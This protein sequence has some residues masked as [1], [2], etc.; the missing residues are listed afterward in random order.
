MEDGDDDEVLLS[1]LE[2]E[3]CL[4]LSR[5]ESL[6]RSSLGESGG[7]RLRPFP[8][9]ELRRQSPLGEREGAC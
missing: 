2:V 1:S 5:E 8:R 3:E 4:R 6:W 9:G 7:A